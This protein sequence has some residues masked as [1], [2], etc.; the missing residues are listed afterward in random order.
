MITSLSE[1]EVVIVCTTERDFEKAKNLSNLLL[2][3]HLAACVNMKDITSSFWWEGELEDSQEIE[4]CIKTN[5]MNLE[6]I[7]KL[8]KEN[9]SYENPELLFW[10]ASTSK[11][12][13]QW[14]DRVTN[15]KDDQ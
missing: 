8:I 2:Q 12:Y 4:L 14:V 9:H 6:A 1:N 13:Y 3:N 11:R 10:I 7:L 15:Y 5:K